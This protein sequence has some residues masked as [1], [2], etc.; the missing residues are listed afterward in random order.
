MCQ[1][2]RMSW[3][4]SLCEGGY[5]VDITKEQVDYIHD[6][7]TD[8]LCSC[9]KYVPYEKPEIGDWCYECSS[10]GERNRDCRIGKLK[11][12]YTDTEFLTETVGGKEIHW[13]NASIKK[14]PSDLMRGLNHG[15]QSSGQMG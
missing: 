2:A 5:R 4:R 9:M 10:W 14:I 15:A 11:M 7:L 13:T 6:V 3:L 8:L 12:I 1:L